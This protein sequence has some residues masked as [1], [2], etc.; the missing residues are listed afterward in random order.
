MISM[1]AS[2][3]PMVQGDIPEVQLIDSIVHAHP[4]SVGNFQDCL[5]EGQ[6]ASVLLLGQE[7]IGYGIYSRLVDEAH[8]LTIAV[9]ASHQ[10]QGWGR[11]LLEYLLDNIRADGFTAVLLEVRPSNIAAIGLYQTEGFVPIGRRDEYYPDVDGREDAIILR[12]ELV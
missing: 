2:I 11:Y 10:R 5:D 9:K 7:L 4:W 8:I 1:Q 3:R 6:Q 12:L